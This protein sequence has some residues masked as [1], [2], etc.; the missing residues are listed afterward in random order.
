MLGQRIPR[1]RNRLPNGLNG[2]ALGSRRE[3]LKVGTSGDPHPHTGSA[4]VNVTAQVRH[5]AHP[6]VGTSFASE[7]WKIDCRNIGLEHRCARAHPDDGV[8]RSLLVPGAKNAVHGYIAKTGAAGGEVRDLDRECAQFARAFQKPG[9]A[10][11]NRGRGT[12]CPAWGRCS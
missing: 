3:D 6:D 9:F 7:I 10:G 4:A 5:G 2:N 1:Q 12:G 8:T 11:D